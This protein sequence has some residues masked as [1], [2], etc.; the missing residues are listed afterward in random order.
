MQK[1]LSLEDSRPW[2]LIVFETLV[3]IA[4]VS[5]LGLFLAKY[6]FFS[7]VSFSKSMEPTVKPDSVVFINRSAYALKEPE[8]FDVVAF[9]RTD[10]RNADI[11]VRRII[12]LP[13]DFVKISRGSVYINGEL[14]DVSGHIA[15]ITSDGIAE[16]G[17]RLS[18]NEYFV[19]GDMPANSEDSRSST[20]GAV[21][22]ERIIGK[23]WISVSSWTE[24]R[25]IR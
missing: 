1:K 11:L 8:R 6:L 18:D 10:D 25:L 9:T 5:V 22:R 3:Q 17:V 24:F 14:L 2:V 7:A 19:L 13:G 12:G 15:E 16:S 20:I 4:V 21:K 23:A